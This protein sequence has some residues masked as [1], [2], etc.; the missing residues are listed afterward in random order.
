MTPLESKK[1]QSEAKK[2]ESNILDAEVKI[3]EHE[4][5]ILKLQDN[6]EA[7]KGR[8]KSLETE[9]KKG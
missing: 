4:N 8:K 5:A 3:M 9:I 6:I 2:M 1:K 7:Y